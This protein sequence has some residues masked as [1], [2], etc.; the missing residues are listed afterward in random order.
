MGEKL[1]AGYNENVSR[2]DFYTFRDKKLCISHNKGI[3][4]AF[5]LLCSIS[6]IP[7][8]KRNV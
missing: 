6:L 8:L 4:R 3:C 1:S 7:F 5:L 2:P